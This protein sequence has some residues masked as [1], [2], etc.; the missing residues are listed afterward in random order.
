MKKIIT[1]FLALT[2]SL[3][4]SAQQK[5][6]F[7][8]QGFWKKKPDVSIVK[9]EI[10]KGNNP[11]E[12]NER[13]F[14]PV[15]FAI[16]NDAPNETIKFLLEQPGNTVTK[17]THDNRR[18]LHW[19]ANK[20]NLEIVNFLIAKGADINYE[21]SIGA[22]AL[23][24]AASSGQKNTEVYEAFF[25]AGLDPKKKYKEGMTL[26]L[27]AIPYD[28]DLSLVEYFS[29]KGLSIKDVDSYGNTAFNLATKTGDLKLLNKIIEKGVKYT[30]GA[31]IFAAQGNRRE[32][33]SLEVYQYLIEQLKLKPTVVSNDGESVL[34]F[35]V[36]KPKQTEIINYLISKGADVN[37]ADKNG[38][39]VLMKA[40]TAKDTEA[41]ELLINSV[42]NSTAVNTKGE[43]ALAMAVQFGTPKAVELLLKKGLDAKIINKEGY[44]LGFYLIQSYKPE[45]NRAPESSN[46]QTEDP[47][48]LKMKLLQDSGLN[49]STPQKDGSTLYHFALLKNDL[50]LLQKINNLGIDINAKNKEGLTAL[51][52]AAMLAKNDT[53]LKYLLSIGAKKDSVTE[54]NETAYALAKENE[55]L[56]KNNISIDFLK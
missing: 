30:D 38:N 7:L 35:L 50:N 18:Y 48:T 10:A 53:I 37:K 8:D 25:K 1:L 17:A 39:T 3:I 44:N 20:G 54:F 32:T 55:T 47:F 19:A 16:N 4:A 49:L 43:S 51:H 36:T 14:D 40:A 42:K 15:V 26:L 33:T 31:L 27:M 52:K 45:S 2:I 11:A 41:L 13:A 21:D 5:N 9:E 24:F 34:H 22:S 23:V 29:S 6:I 28:K 46:S 56:S 12:L